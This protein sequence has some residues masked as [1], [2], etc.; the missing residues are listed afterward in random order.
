MGSVASDPALYD[1]HFA[2]KAEYDVTTFLH[3]DMH[4]PYRLACEYA[5]RNQRKE[6]APVHILNMR[7][8]SVECSLPKMTYTT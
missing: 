4:R 5:L 2:W 1:Q 7:N 8:S 3:M 6:K